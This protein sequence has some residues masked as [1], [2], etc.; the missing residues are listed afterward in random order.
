MLATLRHARFW[1]VLG[2]LLVLGAIYL[3]LTPGSALPKDMLVNDK[4]AHATTYALLT[5]W[6]AGLYPRSRYVWIGLSLFA[7]GVFI[8]FAQ[9]AM[10]LG[11]Q[12]DLLDVAANSMGICLGLMLA[13]A[14]LGD[15]VQRVESWTRRT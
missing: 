7:L 2:W 11:R 13:L 14:W 12:R 8:E 1:Q 4:V 3:S 15:W 6:F 9:G 10:G 5:L